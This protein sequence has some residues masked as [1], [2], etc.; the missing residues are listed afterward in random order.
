MDHVDADDF[1][2][3]NIL[4]CNNDSK[5]HPRH[6]IPKLCRQFY[7]NGWVPGTGGGISIKYN[8]QIFTAPSGVQKEKIEP[9]DLLV[10]NLDGEDIIVPEPEK[11]LSKSQC[12]PIFMCAYTERNAGAVIH[13]YSLE[14]V[15]LCLL[16]PENELRITGL[17]MMKG[18]F[19]EKTGKFYDN[20]EELVIPIIENSKYEKDLVE[21][22]KLALRKYP[23]TSAVLVRNHGMYVWGSS[24]ITAKTQLECYEHLFNTTIFKKTYK[25]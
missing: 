24:W 2:P 15:K 9:D 8:D 20:D 3:T 5:D 4:I 12:T 7:A 25:V 18:I 1:A 19:N 6:L 11:K 14:A 13:V 17:E 10:Q 21:T 16:N 22:F 23:S